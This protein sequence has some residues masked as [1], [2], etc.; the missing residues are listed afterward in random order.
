M[1]NL[2]SHSVELISVLPLSRTWVSSSKEVMQDSQK[3][4][5]YSAVGEF[6]DFKIC[7]NSVS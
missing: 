5:C 7:K 2:V 4:K 1:L 6:I 3:N